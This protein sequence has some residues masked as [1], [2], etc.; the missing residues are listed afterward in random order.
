MLP[1]GRGEKG[2]EGEGEDAHAHPQLLAQLAMSGAWPWLYPPAAMGEPVAQPIF[3]GAVSQQQWIP[4]T[5]WWAPV[6]QP[7]P[8]EE[9]QGKAASTSPGHAP[10]HPP[11]DAP[12][13]KG[14]FPG[15]ELEGKA[16]GKGLE[17]GK[18]KG[19]GTSKHPKGKG[20]SPS[21]GQEVACTTCI[22]A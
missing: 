3:R 14:L 17:A 22:P 5:Q 11:S 16:K 9:P 12:Q 4:A 15:P 10:S 8:W 21:P 6:A 7:T 2:E 1:V 18:G 13:G 19:K 20:L